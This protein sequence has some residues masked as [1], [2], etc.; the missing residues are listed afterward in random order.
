MD[1]FMRHVIVGTCAMIAGYMGPLYLVG[2]FV[3]IGMAL[4]IEKNN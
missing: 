4:L 1:N 3:I 2:F